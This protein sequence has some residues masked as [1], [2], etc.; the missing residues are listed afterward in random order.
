MALSLIIKALVSGLAGFFGI[1]LLVG[2]HE[3]GHFF[4]C[5]LFGVHTPSFSIGFGPRIIEKKIGDTLFALSA[6][7][8]GG[9]V[10]IA[11]L[12]EVGQG[13]QG[14]ATDRSDRSFYYKPYYQKLLILLGGIAVNIASAYLTLTALLI[15]TGLPESTL[16]MTHITE[17]TIASI[18]QDSPAARALLQPGDRIVKINQTTFTENSALPDI[19][20]EIQRNAGKETAITVMRSGSPITV[21][22]Q[23]NPQGSPAIL[24]V[25][26]ASHPIPPQTLYGALTLSGTIIAGWMSSTALMLRT[27]ISQ[28]TTRGLGGP[29]A[30][31]HG[32]AQSASHSATLFLLFL[33][34][35]SVGLACINLVPL[36]IFDGGQVVFYTLE[37]I[38]GR[39]LD[40]ARMIIHYI[41]WILVL[42]AFVYLS[43]QDI[44]RIITG[45]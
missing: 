14:S 28:K 38:I 24:G 45:H 8:L 35:I 31:I 4:L 34:F 22:Q 26:F 19:L 42:I 13:E 23:L 3:L 30:V 12:E 33:A 27:M 32:I 36:P 43:W 18:E 16:I 21:Q 40:S 5:K 44:A 25:R 20:R 2:L 37:A 41:C 9:Y 15:C 10:E 6:I 29:V 11:G 17:P 7:P 39:S 1:S